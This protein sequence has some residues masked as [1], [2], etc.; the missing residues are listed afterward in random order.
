[1]ALDIMATA[2]SI[3]ECVCAALRDTGDWVGTCCVYPGASV[4]WD[5]CCEKGG[6]AWVAM[7]AG[8]PTRRFPAQ[9]ATSGITRCTDGHTLAVRFEVGVLRCA[10]VD[11]C[12]CT[13]REQNAALVFGDLEAVL[14]GLSCCFAEESTSACGDLDWRLLNF[15][16]TGPQGGCVGS[17]VEIVVNLP[18]PCCSTP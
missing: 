10:C 5:S 14:A 17:R 18:A 9:D 13:K 2:Q 15:N 11:N 6:Q 3:S 16:L 7:L 4:P 8:Y 12:D 1:M